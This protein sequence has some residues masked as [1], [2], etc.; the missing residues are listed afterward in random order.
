[1]RDPAEWLHSCY[2]F[3]I[4]GN[5]QI[6]GS[7]V[8]IQSFEDYL[9]AMIDLGPKKPSQSP[10]FISLDGDLLVDEIGLFH[11]LDEFFERISI[12][13]GLKLPRLEHLNKN[14]LACRDQ[15]SRLPLDRLSEIIEE[16]WKLDL[17]MWNLVVKTNSESS[18]RGYCL[19]KCGLSMMDLRDYDPWGQ[20]EWLA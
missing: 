14:S 17:R 1:M 11:R 16:H 12:K 9:K 20:F 3:F 13:I 5:S 18:L 7:R 6:K 10:M 4:K 8:T 19:G 2:K 15:M